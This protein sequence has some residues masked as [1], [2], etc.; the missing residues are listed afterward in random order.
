MKLPEGEGVNDW[1]A[2][3]VVDFFNEV[4]LLL[5]LVMTELTTRFPNAGDGFPPGFEYRWQSAGKKPLRVSAPEYCDYVMSWIESQLDNPS[6]F[7]VM[8]TDPFPD[9]FA[10]YIKDIYKRMFRIFAIMF[11]RA[12]DV[13]EGID[14][15]AHLNTVFKHFIFFGLEFKLLPDPKECDVLKGPMEK[16]AADFKTA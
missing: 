8:E 16:L 3:N 14:A 15:T 10:D 5:G 2:A 13:F 1:L 6:I 11:R 7:P 12:Y 4:S 9:D